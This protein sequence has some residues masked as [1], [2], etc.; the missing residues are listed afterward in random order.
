MIIFIVDHLT[1]NDAS[2]DT[3]QYHLFSSDVAQP[4]SSLWRLFLKKMVN[5]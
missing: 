2:G 4:F 5:D 1:T 3:Y